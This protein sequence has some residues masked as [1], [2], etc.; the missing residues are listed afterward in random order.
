MKVSFD[1]DCTLDREDVQLYAKS[2][3]KQGY[4]VYITTSRLSNEKAPSP[5]WN[6]DLY[7]VCDIV[8]IPKDHITFTSYTDKADFFLEN[9]D[10]IFHLD[11]DFWELETMKNYHCKTVGI[12]VLSPSYQAKCNEILEKKGL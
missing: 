6:E 4:K 10:F 2:L 11:D 5:S 3:I 12:S 8:G 7:I 1:F 9:P